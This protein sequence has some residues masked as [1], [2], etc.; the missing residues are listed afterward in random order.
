MPDPSHLCNIHHSSWQCRIL[1]PL[2][3]ARDWAYNLMVAN[4]IR[5]CCT[6]MG[7]PIMNISWVW[8]RTLPQGCNV[9][10]WLLLPGLCVPSLPW[11]ATA[12]WNSGN[13][14]EARASS[15]NTRN[16]GH[17]RACARDPHR[18]LLSFAVRR[19]FIHV[20]PFIFSGKICDDVIS[21]VLWVPLTLCETHRT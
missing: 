9:V 21:L 6:K 2:S 4:Q 20:I 14:Q 19:N 8:N 10:S 13:V 16:E 11:L 7:T 18:A 3:E 17:R 1:N 12:L 5:F 15:L